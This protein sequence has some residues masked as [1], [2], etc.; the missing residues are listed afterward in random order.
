MCSGG[1][2]FLNSETS[3]LKDLDKDALDGKV[4]GQGG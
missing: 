4:I 3:E 2:S 1:D